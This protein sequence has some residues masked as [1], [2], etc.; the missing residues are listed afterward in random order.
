MDNCDCGAFWVNIGFCE[1][2]SRNVD[3]FLRNAP[4][5]EESGRVP[6]GGE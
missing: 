2:K 1:A 3:D 6:V 5:D 4:L